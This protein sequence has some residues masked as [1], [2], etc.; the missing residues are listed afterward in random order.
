MNSRRLLLCLAFGPLSIA[1]ACSNTE[2]SAGGERVGVGRAAITTNPPPAG[3]PAPPFNP[4]W[5]ND[6]ERQQYDVSPYCLGTYSF[7]DN[8]GTQYCP[9]KYGNDYIFSYC[10]TAGDLTTTSYTA[11]QQLYCVCC[12][13][14]LTAT[15]VNRLGYR[16]LSLAY[17]PPGNASSVAYNKSSL[18]GTQVQIQETNQAGGACQLTSSALTVS[19][20]WVAGSVSGTTSQVVYT[21]GNGFGN[22]ANP[23][24]DAINHENDLFELWTSPE[25]LRT[26]DYA[27]G[28]VT[29]AIQDSAD[30]KVVPVHLYELEHPEQMSA[31]LAQLLSALTADDREAIASTDPWHNN[32]NFDPYKAPE[33]FLLERRNAN[34][35]MVSP[36]TPAESVPSATISLDTTTQDTVVSGEQTN[37]QVQILMGAKVSWIVEG[38]I[39][40]GVQYDYQYQKLHGAMTGTDMNASAVL[41]SSTQCFTQVV[42]AWQDTMFNSYAFTAN[43]PAIVQCATPQAISSLVASGSPVVA[44]AIVNSGGTRLPGVEVNVNLQLEGGATQLY[45]TTTHPDGTFALTSIPKFVSATVTSGSGT[46]LMTQPAPFSASPATL[47][48][49]TNS[50]VSTKI[51]GPLAALM[52]PLSYTVTAP[53]GVTASVSPMGGSDAEL[54]LTVGPDVPAQTLTVTVTGTSGLGL[55]SSIAIPITVSAC[56]LGF[57]QYCGDGTYQCGS[58]TDTCGHQR[59][60]GGCASG[61]TCSKNQCCPTGQVYNAD[62][63]ACIPPT[64]HVPPTH[65]THG[66]CNL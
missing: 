57:P 45:R 35:V 30:S 36:S 8:G 47:S 61:Q 37:V 39:Q 43:A 54:T 66:A 3:W 41:A 11:S 15:T 63:A 62:L 4:P 29:Y 44:G 27:S 58:F 34:I 59:A 6:Y 65:C 24:G 12:P 32:P 53:P 1:A 46:P 60:C 5:A 13:N 23:L 2:P 21:G 31:G 33:R 51:S 9:E 20:S 25:V 26:V 7:A 50:S 55:Q 16:I 17:A 48:A 64:V 42:A 56:Q 10:H 14:W 38:G 19:A 28:A 22:G 18:T 52:G 49:V 40:L